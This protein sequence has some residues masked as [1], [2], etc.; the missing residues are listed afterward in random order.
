MRRNAYLFCAM[1]LL[2]MSACG[3]LLEIDREKVAEVGG[4]PIRVRDL[5]S[6]IRGLDFQER[7]KANDTDT[8]VRIATRRRILEMMVVERL[9]ALEAES[10]GIEVTDEE[11]LLSLG[12]AEE[13]RD[14]AADAIDG[15]ASGSSHEREKHSRWELEEARNKLL[16]G[17]LQEEE[18][19]EAALRRF[20]DEH[21]DEFKMSSPLVNYE[22]ISVIPK[23]R[24]T[25]DT[26]YRLMTEKGMTMPDA[27][28]SIGKPADIAS[29][30]ITP[31][32]P[33]DKLPQSFRENVEGLGKKELSKPF[34]YGD[35]DK[36]LYTIAR[37]V[38]VIRKRPFEAGPKD[39]IHKRLSL[40]WIQRL[41]EKFE[42]SYYDEKL[43]YRVEG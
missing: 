17:K 6:R 39:E 41:K 10:R 20:Y 32:M 16:I 2:L 30:G 37:R 23:N 1:W 35:D 26:V 4:E 19:S 34:Y 9:M 42:V 28:E 14:E 24:A 33:L 7:A 22:I 18:L 31:T 29:I 27:Y 11:I 36:K 12:G 25:V 5:Q 21:A 3:W 13:T 40:L 8:E 15:G 43:E 38:R